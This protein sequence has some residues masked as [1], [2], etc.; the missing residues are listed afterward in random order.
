MTS[1]WFGPTPEIVINKVTASNR[2]ETIAAVK[3]WTGLDPVAV[4]PDRQR[5]RRNSASGRPPD[6]AFS[7]LL[8]GVGG[9][10]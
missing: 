10:A 5:V 9:G 1:N 3:R 2:V 6:R 8:T 4:I 7:R